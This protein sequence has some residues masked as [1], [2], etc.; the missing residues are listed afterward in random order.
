M[1]EKAF[2]EKLGS[3]VDQRYEESMTGKH[4]FSLVLAN[5]TGNWSH[6][7]CNQDHKNRTRELESKRLEVLSPRSATCHL[8]YAIGAADYLEMHFIRNG[9]NTMQ[10]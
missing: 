2:R 5:V 3:P 1:I 7:K 4:L 6:S 10:P 9:L 8:A